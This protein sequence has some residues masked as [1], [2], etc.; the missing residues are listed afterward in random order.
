MSDR[1]VILVADDEPAPRAM[2]ELML[3]REGYDVLPAG[4]GAEAVAVAR[5]RTPGAIL[6]DV[7]MPEM[8]GLEAC[9][10]LKS[11]P[12]TR[13]VPL[14][15]LTGNDMPSDILAGFAAGGDDYVLK[16]PLLQVLV[17]RV[18][19]Q[20]NVRRLHRQNLDYINALHAS[21]RDADVG[22]LLGGVAHNYNNMLAPA[23]SNAEALARSLD[24]RDLL[25]AQEIAGDIRE[26]LLKLKQFNARVSQIRRDPPEPGSRVDLA[27]ILPPVVEFFAASLPSR[28]AF[29]QSAAPPE[30]TFL[31][32]AAGLEDAVLALLVNAREALERRGGPGR[33]AIEV[34]PSGSGPDRILRIRV[35]DD[36]PGI[37]EADLENAF[38][39]FFTSKATVGAGLGLTL[40]RRTAESLRGRLTLANRAEGGFEALV[41]IPCPEVA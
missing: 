33:I 12:A 32:P 1:E 40:S 35:R 15:F 6:M 21:R 4:T 23:L 39:P 10:I 31:L 26:A 14:I 22:L 36:G 27:R 2:V 3:R 29:E 7:N 5:A 38:L 19:A 25:D 16:P 17:A 8:D 20:I 34:T 41:E 9:R 18:R 28:I 37:P 13:E 24:A 30:E 11:D